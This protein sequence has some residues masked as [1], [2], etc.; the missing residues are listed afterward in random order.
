MIMIIDDQ[1]KYKIGL[2][3]DVEDRCRLITEKKTRD[4]EEKRYIKKAYYRYIETYE[5]VV[6]DGDDREAVFNA[7][8]EARREHCSKCLDIVLD[9]FEERFEL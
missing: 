4:P 6:R 2:P 9:Y 7:W 5:W 1:N 8:F 3:Q